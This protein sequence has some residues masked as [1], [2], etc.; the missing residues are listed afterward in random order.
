MSYFRKNW[1]GTEVT[2]PLLCGNKIINVGLYVF[3]F[4]AIEK[5]AGY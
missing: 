4:G 1:F 3:S 5:C 2:F